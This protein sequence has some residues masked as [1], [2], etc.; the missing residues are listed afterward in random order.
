R[1]GSFCHPLVS[2]WAVPFSGTPVSIPLAPRFPP[3]PHG[4]GALSLVCG[5]IHLHRKRHA[6]ASGCTDLPCQSGTLSL[7]SQSDVPGGSCDSDRA[8]HP[9][10]LVPAAW[11]CS[12]GMGSG[13]SVCGFRRGTISPPPV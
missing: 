8:G 7:G 11:I 6:S 4:S 13:S 2:A 1:N 5:S 3:S 12:A 9:L 10:S